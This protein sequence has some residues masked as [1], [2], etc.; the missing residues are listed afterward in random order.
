MF[1]LALSSGTVKHATYKYR[2]HITSMPKRRSV[3]RKIKRLLKQHR[4]AHVRGEYDRALGNAI[5]HG[6]YPVKVT[7]ALTASKCLIKVA[8]AGKGFDYRKMIHKFKTGKRY[9]HNH[10][11]GTKC[12][13]RNAHVR[14][15]WDHHGSRILL[16]YKVR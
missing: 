15:N 4:V 13:A 16:L 14:V 6:A 11:Y 3:A 7:I 8:D 12:L 10:G 5:R 9:W 1:D 2:F